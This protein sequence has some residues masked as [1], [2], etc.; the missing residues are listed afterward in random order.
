MDRL[1]LMI[2]EVRLALETG[3]LKKVDID[4]RTDILNH[5]DVQ[6]F[7]N[8]RNGR[9]IGVGGE[10]NYRG[11]SFEFSVGYTVDGF[12]RMR[13]KKKGEK[14][15]DVDINQEAF[16]FLYRVYKAFFF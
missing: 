9:I 5:P 14:T 15:G 1:K 4:G 6:H 7:I 16:D 10:M 11:V 3:D 12:G 2:K 8:N 13:I